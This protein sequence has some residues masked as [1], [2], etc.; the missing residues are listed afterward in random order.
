AVLLLGPAWITFTLGLGMSPFV[1][2]PLAAL[3]V[4]LMLPLVQALQP[5]GRRLVA[6][7]LALAVAVVAVS[8]VGARRNS[9]DAGQPV[10]AE[11]TYTLDADTG[12]AQW[13]IP[14]HPFRGAAEPRHPWLDNLV[15]QEGPDPTPGRPWPDPRADVG[16]ADP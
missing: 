2:A 3:G 16:A 5:V 1:V 4:L 7:A 15:G 12:Q 6:T 9:P 8:A 14:V 11:L 13:A 10:P